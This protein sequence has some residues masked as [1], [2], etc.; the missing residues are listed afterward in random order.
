MDKKT[1]V[2]RR[3]FIYEFLTKRGF[4][5]YKIATDKFDCTKTV[6]LYDETPE[7]RDAVEE[8]YSA[9]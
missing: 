6:W 4:V 8:C 7:L 1:Y 3:V 9:R 2:C 5:P